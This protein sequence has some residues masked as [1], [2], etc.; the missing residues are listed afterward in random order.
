MIRKLAVDKA[1][2][3]K[4]QLMMYRCIC[5]QIMPISTQQLLLFCMKK[6]HSQS[7]NVDTLKSIVVERDYRPNENDEY[8]NPKQLKYFLNKLLEWKE[9]LENELAATMHELQTET[10][11]EA[12]PLNTVSTEV[13]WSIKLKSR[14]RMLKLIERIDNAINRIYN[15]TYGYC[16]ETGEEIGL[17][18]LEAR[19]IATLCIE[20]QE[21]HERFE[22]THSDE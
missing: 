11:N 10:W 7:T 17:R 5:F 18:R 8:M 20:A 6:L 13:V 1:W 4:M 16:E 3:T 14:N 9:I 19:P 22:N 12:D 15:G 21:A 2:R